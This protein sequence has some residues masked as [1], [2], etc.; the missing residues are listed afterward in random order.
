LNAAL[1]GLLEGVSIHPGEIIVHFAT[2]VE[3]LESSWLG[4]GYWK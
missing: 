2:P 1:T 3:A 4:N